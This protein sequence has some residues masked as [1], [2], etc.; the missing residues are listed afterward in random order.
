MHCRLSWEEC[1]GRALLYAIT[2]AYSLSLMMIFM[3]FNGWIMLA[4]IGGAFLGHFYWNWMLPEAAF[5][6]IGGTEQCELKP[7][8][9][10]CCS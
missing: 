3:T 9:R 5:V 10:S 1:L 7:I 8:A 6:V 2:S 4:Q